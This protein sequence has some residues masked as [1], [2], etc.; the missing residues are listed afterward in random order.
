[1]PPVNPRGPDGEAGLQATK[2]GLYEE[3]PIVPFLRV[4]PFP[5]G[6]NMSY[7]PRHR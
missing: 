3:R 5:P 6:N 4:F 2:Q 1:M 7:H